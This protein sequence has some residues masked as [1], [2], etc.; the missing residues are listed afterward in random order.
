MPS[1]RTPK[2]HPEQIQ[3][4]H[5]ADVEPAPQHGHG[6]HDSAHHDHEHHDHLHEPKPGKHVGSPAVHG[7]R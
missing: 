7:H 6:H 2:G 4:S 3:T 5:D 1:T